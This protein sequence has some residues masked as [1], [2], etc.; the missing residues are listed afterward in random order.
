VSA[1]FTAGSD[2]FFA[3]FIPHNGKLLLTCVRLDWK[4]GKLR[5]VA[6]AMFSIPRDAAEAA[7][8]PC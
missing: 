1:V 8:S 4:S 2:F 6:E 5:D 3:Q 7:R